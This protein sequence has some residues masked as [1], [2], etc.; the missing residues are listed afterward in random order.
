MRRF[1]E[2]LRSSTIECT[3]LAS[4]DGIEDNESMCLTGDV[5]LRIF[6]IQICPSRSFSDMKPLR[7]RDLAASCRRARFV[8]IDFIVTRETA[9]R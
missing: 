3:M 6:S 4:I 5:S 1:V 8:G 2:R 9:V 7:L